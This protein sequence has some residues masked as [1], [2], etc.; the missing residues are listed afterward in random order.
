MDSF[1]FSMGS[2]LVYSSMCSSRVTPIVFKTCLH[3]EETLDISKLS[4]SKSTPMCE[5]CTKLEG[6]DMSSLV[7]LSLAFTA[8]RVGVVVYERSLTSVSCDV[9]MIGLLTSAISFITSSFSLDWLY[10]WSGLLFV[11]FSLDWTASLKS[12]ASPSSAKLNPTIS[13]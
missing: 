2:F 5:M 7:N 6:F 3:S 13:S 9:P 10:S 4:P 12:L 11:Q 8:L 1:N